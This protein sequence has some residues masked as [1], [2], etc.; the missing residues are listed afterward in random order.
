MIHGWPTCQVERNPL[1]SLR[2]RRHTVLG[3]GRSGP[4]PLPH[5]WA[6]ILGNRT[7]RAPAL[8][9]S[10]APV[11][12]SRCSLLSGPPV[13]RAFGDHSHQ[14]ADG[15]ATAHDGAISTT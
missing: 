6:H 15:R 12:N 14:P 2:T 8:S 3:S 4:M 10:P 13:G 11:I 9:H 1:T 5:R 7:I